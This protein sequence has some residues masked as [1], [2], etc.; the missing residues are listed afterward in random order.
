MVDQAESFCARK[1][2][3][4]YCDVPFWFRPKFQPEVD[5]STFIEEIVITPFAEAWQVAGIKGAIEA[6]L[7]EVGAEQIPVRQSKHMR[8]P[9]LVW[10]QETKTRSE[11]ESKTVVTPIIGET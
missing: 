2:V 8:V 1:E 3:R 9:Q 4:L 10:P 11:N 6:L 7:K 5:L